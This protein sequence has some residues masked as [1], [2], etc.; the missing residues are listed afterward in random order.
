[1]KCS[2]AVELAVG[3]HSATVPG[4]YSMNEGQTDPRSGKFV[5]VMQ[6]L[7]NAE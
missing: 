5:I 2:T 1:V 4:H 7:K 6:A 3:P